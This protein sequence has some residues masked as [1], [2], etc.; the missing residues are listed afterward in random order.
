MW[1]VS[2]KAK[3]RTGI[4]RMEEEFPKRMGRG[5]RNL[6]DHAV[7]DTQPPH[8]AATVPLLPAASLYFESQNHFSS[9]QDRHI[10]P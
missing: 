6:S 9:F 5:E 2:V 1:S 10:Q 7:F 3:V 4:G 8:E